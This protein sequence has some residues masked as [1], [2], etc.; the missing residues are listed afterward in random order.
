[1]TLKKIK[2]LARMIT[3]AK[4]FFNINTQKRKGIKESF[5]INLKNIFENLEEVTSSNTSDIMKEEA[6]KLAGKTKKELLV[7]SKED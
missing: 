2:R 6:R 7:L 4:T 1:M 5:E 3:I